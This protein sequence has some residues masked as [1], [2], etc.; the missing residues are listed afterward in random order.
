MRSDHY[1][2]I[3]IKFCH[4]RFGAENLNISSLIIQM[5]RF[6]WFFR[7]SF[8]NTDSRK[9][10][11]SLI[12]KYCGEQESQWYALYIGELQGTYKLCFSVFET[13]FWK[14]IYKTVRSLLALKDNTCHLSYTRAFHLSQVSKFSDMIFEMS[15]LHVLS[16]PKASFLKVE[17]AESRF[18]KA[19]YQTWPSF[20][21]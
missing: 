12:V 9:Q 5:F 6:I 13:S 10:W 21:L 3:N 15:P 7:G 8:S 2:S 1:D 19:F 18:A 11:Y 4:L 16:L 14:R 17:E 20:R